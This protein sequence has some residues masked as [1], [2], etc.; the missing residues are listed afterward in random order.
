MFATAN[1]RPTVVNSGQK[2]IATAC[3]GNSLRGKQTPPS[4]P[5]AE[6][7]PSKGSPTM[8]ALLPSKS[9][10][11][12]VGLI[13]LSVTALSGVALA[14]VTP[15]NAFKAS[16]APA[17][18]STTTNA[19]TTKATN[20]EGGQWTAPSNVSA[21]KSASKSYVSA[22]PSADGKTIA[23]VWTGANDIVEFASTAD[24]GVT[25]SSPVAI[26]T[27]GGYTPQITA[28]TDGSKLTAIWQAAGY[29]VVSA[30]S[31]DGGHTWSAPVDVPHKA[32]AMQV[33]ISASADGEALLATWNTQGANVEGATSNDGGA[34]WTAA[35]L[36]SSP[37]QEARAETSA[38][39]KVMTVAWTASDGARIATSIDSGKSWSSA[40][41]VARSGAVDNPQIVASDDGSQLTV[42]WDLNSGT[43]AGI[44]T[45]TSA[46][47]GQAW[48]VASTLSTPGRLVQAPEIAASSDG[49]TLLASWTTKRGTTSL[50]DVHVATKSATDTSWSAPKVLGAPSRT[51][52]QPQVAVSS[53]G[54]TMNVL[55]DSH[56]TDE[57]KSTVHI[58][59]SSNS[60]Q[61]WS[62]PTAV[63]KTPTAMSAFLS[64]LVTSAD[65]RTVTALWTASNADMPT[66][67]IQSATD[68][69][70][71][72]LTF[73]PAD[74][75]GAVAG[76]AT[77]LTVEVT[78][79]GGTNSG[80]A[81]TPSAITAA[82][83]GVTVTGGT[84]A[85]GS[86]IATGGSCT[87]ELSWTPTA[88][89]ALDAASLKV[90]YPGG[91]KASDEVAL[92][93]AAEPAPAP[94]P[95]PAPAPAPAPAPD[96]PS[97]NSRNSI[98]QVPLRGCVRVGS[99]K[100]M[101]RYGSK[102]LM[103]SNCVTNAGQRVVVKVTA[104]KKHAV[105]SNSLYAQ[106]SKNKKVG[107]S[108]AAG[109]K[110]YAK[111][112]SLRIRTYGYKATYKVTWSAPAVGD[113]AGYTYTKTYKR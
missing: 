60:G 73:G 7:K 65:G 46:N 104:N 15:A 55:W 34:T 70:R 72:P 44:Q 14:G 109:G 22:A 33:Q 68:V 111:K 93:G 48:T 17:S 28:S 12:T 97:A 31:S 53:G 20:S 71:G 66:G 61:S 76:S 90:A 87:V 10:C 69:V 107:A 6:P 40:T 2:S 64:R 21:P 3:T 82:G 89:G 42:T 19:V 24:G 5:T 98:K 52:Q 103:K 85:V 4:A 16:Q 100:S 27:S 8:S 113:Y 25:W 62:N 101:P 47:L 106:V 79:S 23:A 26:S 108:L 18:S 99:T 59:S 91:V 41:L 88:A 43:D 30:S 80:G 74:F 11:R 112:G 58:A 110:R 29:S 63:S 54:T 105:R 102:E 75:T 32:S 57:G 84:C 95:G 36:P 50:F 78:N 92:S 81:I 86:Q 45:A 38:N 77:P 83:S 9:T 37:S 51:P 13:A 67:T 96:G 56:S 1:I 94:A 35:N 39:G 49:K